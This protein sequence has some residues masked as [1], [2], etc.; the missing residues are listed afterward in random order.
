M[1]CENTEERGIRMNDK[2][3][4]T[5]EEAEGFG[6]KGIDLLNRMT[7]VCY[8][9]ALVCDD[10][11]LGQ[12]LKEYAEDLGFQPEDSKYLFKNK[13]TGDATSDSSETVAGL[14]LQTGD[15]LVISDNAHII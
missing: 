5:A 3:M 4:K 14:K 6:I 10:N 8:P 1:R 2:P 12:I 15:I 7:G 11:T 9:K 13:R